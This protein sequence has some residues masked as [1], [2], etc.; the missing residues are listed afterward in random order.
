MLTRNASELREKDGYFDQYRVS[1]KSVCPTGG[2]VLLSVASAEVPYVKHCS[3]LS[4]LEMGKSYIY[5]KLQVAYLTCGTYYWGHFQSL[6][7]CNIHCNLRCISD[8]YTG[9][10]RQVPACTLYK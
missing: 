10:F 9:S 5:R 2:M 1:R 6:F 3:S 4:E 8:R 7:Y